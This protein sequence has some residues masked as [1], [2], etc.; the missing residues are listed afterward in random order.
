MA[1]TVGIPLAIG[2]KMMMLGE[3]SLK[4]VHMPVLPELYRPILKELEEYGVKFIEEDL[5]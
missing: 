1:I 5:D 4:G 3:T 2:V